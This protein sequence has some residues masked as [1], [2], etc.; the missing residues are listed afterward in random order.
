MHILRQWHQLHSN[1]GSW[2]AYYVQCGGG[3]GVS[4]RCLG[5]Q[6]QTPGICSFCTHESISCKHSD[7]YTLSIFAL[8]REE[9]FGI[10]L[11]HPWGRFYIPGV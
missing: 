5:Q 6:S 9:G 3:V 10:P 7:F 2:H 8:E 1:L 11:S 4:R